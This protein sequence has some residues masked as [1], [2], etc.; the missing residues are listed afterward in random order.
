M[1]T[2]DT[3]CRILGEIVRQYNSK[4][5]KFRIAL[6]SVG[7]APLFFLS[8]AN[9]HPMICALV[10]SALL[11]LSAV[12]RPALKWQEIIVACKTE[13]V[14]WVKIKKRY[15]ALWRN[16][17]EG[18]SFDEAKKQFAEIDKDDGALEEIFNDLIP[19]D[20]ELIKKCQKEVKQTWGDGRGNSPKQGAILEQK[21]A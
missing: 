4:D 15:I 17:N 12:I 10:A 21:P 8:W 19:S 6:G 13:R 3:Q 16:V 1:L 5:R 11:I 18:L 2:A 14:F 20:K 7:F 9:E